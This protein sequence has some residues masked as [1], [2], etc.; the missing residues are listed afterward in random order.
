MTKKKVSPTRINTQVPETFTDGLP[1]PKIF[2]FDLDYTLWP[3][4]IDTHV[5]PPLKPASSDP[6][7]PNTYMIDACGSSF[8][9]Y[10]EVPG[11]LYSARQKGISMGLASRTCAPDLAGIMLKS[12]VALPPCTTDEDNQEKQPVKAWDFFTYREIYPGCKITHF[13]SIYTATKKKE[14]DGH[15]V[16]YEDMIFFDDEERNRDVEEEHGVTFVLVED[17]LTRAEVDRGVREWR[18]RRGV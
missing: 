16:A 13:N 10:D 4:W 8:S 9:F 11:I 18:R 1:L 5:S 15:Q 2:V 3:F 6:S 17:G 7:V 12:V 14:S